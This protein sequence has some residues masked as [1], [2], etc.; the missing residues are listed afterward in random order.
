LALEEFGGWFKFFEAEMHSR[1]CRVAA[2]IKCQ[3]MHMLNFQCAGPHQFGD[4]DHTNFTTLS[5]QTTLREQSVK[6]ESELLANP[7]VKL[8]VDFSFWHQ[9]GRI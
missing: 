1:G 9:L 3:A 8:G 4:Q 6:P 5:R 2:V 7:E